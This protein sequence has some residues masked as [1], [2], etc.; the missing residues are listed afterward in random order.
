MAGVIYLAVSKRSGRKMR[1]TALIALALMLIT[2]VI[3]MIQIFGT[4]VA[5][6]GPVY[7]DQEPANPPPIQNS[8]SGIIL[9]VI[10]VLLLLFIAVVVISVR[11]ERRNISTAKTV[12]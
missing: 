7:P 11:S 12:P 1:I 9:I 3:C 5:E 4:P 8:S 6:V 2:A 10:F